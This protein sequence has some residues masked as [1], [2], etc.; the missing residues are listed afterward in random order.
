[1]EIQLSALYTSSTTSAQPLRESCLLS[2]ST[3]NMSR[4]SLAGTSDMSH[5]R[6]TGFLFLL[7]FSNFAASRFLELTLIR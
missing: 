2:V 6:G 1:M 3:R 7:R 5:L 4:L